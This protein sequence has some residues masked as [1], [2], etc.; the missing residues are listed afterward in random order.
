MNIKVIDSTNNIK[1]SYKVRLNIN[2]LEGFLNKFNF[3]NSE[4]LFI[5]SSQYEQIIIINIEEKTRYN[6][7]KIKIVLSGLTDKTYKQAYKTVLDTFYKG[8]WDPSSLLFFLLKNSY[9]SPSLK[10]NLNLYW[11]P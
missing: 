2:K 8:A 5:F 4:D 3:I 7:Y 9:L 6:H 11:E 10:F 1:S